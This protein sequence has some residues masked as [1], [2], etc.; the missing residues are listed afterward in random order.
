MHMSITALCDLHIFIFLKNCEGLE[1]IHSLQVN[2]LGCHA[3]MDAAED[4]IGDK[5]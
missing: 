3:L 2:K 5:A 1:V 4:R